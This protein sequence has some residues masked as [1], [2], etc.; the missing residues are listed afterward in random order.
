MKNFVNRKELLESMEYL[1]LLS[2]KE[3]RRYSIELFK[4][5][6][7]R[8][9][10][11]NEKYNLEESYNDFLIYNND[12]EHSTTKVDPFRAIMNYENKDFIL[13]IY[14]NTIKRRQKTKILL[15]I[16]WKNSIERL[17]N[18]IRFF[19]KKHIRFNSPR[20]YKN[21]KTKRSGL[22]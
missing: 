18:L 14:E 2:A 5:S 9:D 4:I 20:Y 22:L 16:F 8:K 17:F 6:L 7:P 21:L 1:I 19:D 10:H 11:K 12:R 15:K 3:H 13:K